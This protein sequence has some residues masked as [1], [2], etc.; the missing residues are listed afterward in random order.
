MLRREMT[1][2]TILMHNI[3]Q[4]RTH[5]EYRQPRRSTPIDIDTM[6]LV[7]RH[8]LEID[9]TAVAARP[10]AGHTVA[11]LVGAK[12]L[13]E[14]DVGEPD[15]VCDFAGADDEVAD[16]VAEGLG[17]EPGDDALAPALSGDF[18]LEGL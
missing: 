4:S 13:R 3:R 15:G 6:S 16:Y 9:E 12:G 2:G 18:L 1:L 10:D 11:G 5:Y 8:G 17:F 7:I 14:D